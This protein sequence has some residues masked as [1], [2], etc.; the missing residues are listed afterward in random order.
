[1]SKHQGKLELY[2]CRLRAG[3]KPRRI[4][5]EPHE[6]HRHRQAP[7]G[8]NELLQERIEADLNNIQNNRALV[9]SFF[10]SQMSPILVTDE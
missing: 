3:I 6:A 10:T 4:G 9:R 2:S 1:M 5:L 8:R 7:P